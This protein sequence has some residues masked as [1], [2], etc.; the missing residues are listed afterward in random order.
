MHP[1][2]E[3]KRKIGIERGGRVEKRKRRREEELRNELREELSR[4]KN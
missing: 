2:F 4:E 3:E 1:D